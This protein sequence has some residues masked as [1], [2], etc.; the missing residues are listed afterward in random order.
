M[1]NV[2]AFRMRVTPRQREMLR[3]RLWVYADMLFDEG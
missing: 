3:I 2:S 1:G